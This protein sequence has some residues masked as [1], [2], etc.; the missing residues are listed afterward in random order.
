MAR[1]RSSISQIRGFLYGL[2][3]LLGDISAISKGPG[4]TGKRIGRRAAGKAT[5]R[6]LRK[7]FK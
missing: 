5:G 6:M 7:L 4:A 3:K 1:K 2:A